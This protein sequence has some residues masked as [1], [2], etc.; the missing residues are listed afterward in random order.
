MQALAKQY[1]ANY[2]AGEKDIPLFEGAKELLHELRRRGY[3]QAVATGKGRRG[4]NLAI[5]R[6][7]LGKCFHATRTVD[8]CFSKPHP[9]MLDALMD[10][11]VVVPARTL[12]IGD[13]SYDLQMAKNAGVQSLAVT[14]GAQ[15]KEKL[16]TYNPKEIFD[17]FND[18]SHWLLHYA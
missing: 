14:F 10:N 11:L 1:T 5:E 17:E 12:M 13:S 9:Q 7:E 6:S 8:E 3:K 4:L 2:F 16:L 15:S 18:L